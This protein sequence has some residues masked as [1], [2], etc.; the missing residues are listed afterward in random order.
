VVTAYILKGKRGKRYVGITKKLSRRLQEHRIK[1]TKGG[2]ILG[3]FLVPRTEEFPDYKT[4][5]QRE[6]F[7]KSGQGRKWLDDR[8]LLW[9]FFH[10]PFSAKS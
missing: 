7:L 6:K 2:E 5:R 10:F 9:D 3:D 1:A 4:A 8:K